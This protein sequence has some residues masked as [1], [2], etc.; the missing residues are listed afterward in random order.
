[1]AATNLR[2]SVLVSAVFCDRQ[3]TPESR[4]SIGRSVHEKFRAVA[5]RDRAAHA[6][7]GARA[8]PTGA[9]T[10]MVTDATSAA[11][12]GANVIVKNSD[13]GLKRTLI[14]S[15]TGGSS[16]SVLL[17]GSYEVTADAEGFRR[18]VRAA[19]V[20]SGD[21]T[22]VKLVMQVGGSSE[23]LTV[24]GASPQIRYESAE[25]NGVVSRP[26]IDGLP[27]NGRNSLELTKLEPGA[28]RPA[29]TST[30]RILVPLLGAPGGQNGRATRV[31]VDGGSVMEV[32]NGGVAMG[33]SE[34][35]VEEIQVSRVN[36]DLSTGATASG[37]VNVATRSGGNE[38]HGS[39]FYFFRDHSLS[40]Y[41]ALHRDPFNPDPFFQRQQ[42]G[43]S[44]G[45]PIRQTRA[46]FFASFERLDA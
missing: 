44:L 29:K 36:F 1:L 6:R 16:A 43:V 3:V 26:Q 7:N 11:I 18:L 9:I 8:V 39:G 10:G 28:Q 19:T 25:V 13:S 31:T 34:E 2:E 30:N 32:G 35:T 45:G 21:T 38:L 46:F 22:D 42:F 24:E 23:N 12:R 33:F 14:T 20:E 4:G 17:P 5:P 40:A 37:V 15:D 27:V 41:P